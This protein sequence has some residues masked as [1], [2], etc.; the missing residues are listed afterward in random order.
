MITG[1][2]EIVFNTPEQVAG[3]LTEALNLIAE[4]DPPTDLRE[5]AF[6]KACDMI[7]GK[8]VIVEQAA[9]AFTPP[10][11]GQNGR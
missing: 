1:R 11:L 7:S 10:L 4:L 5:V 6:S 9:P 3:Y 2:K 8:Q